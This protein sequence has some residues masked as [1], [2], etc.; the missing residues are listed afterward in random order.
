MFRVGVKRRYGKSLKLSCK[1]VTLVLLAVVVVLLLICGCMVIMKRKFLF[2][3]QV[4]LPV[5]KPPRTVVSVSSF[6]QR[7][8]HMQECLDSIMEQSMLADRVIVT[9]PLKFRGKEETS[10]VGWSD[11]VEYDVH[12]NENV[13]SMVEWFGRYMGIPYRYSVQ[14]HT[15]T[16]KTLFLY[17]FGNLT[18]QFLESD[19]G[20]ATKLIGALLL[21]ADPET[22]I[23]T[24][25][26]DMVYNHETVQWLSTHIQPNIALSFGCES[27]SDDTELYIGGLATGH[28]DTV[29]WVLESHTL[30]FL[31]PNPRIC[32]G[33]LLG[34]EGVAY[35]TS[36]FGPDIWKFLQSLPVGC[37]YNDDIWLSG[38]VARRGVRR[39]ASL[40]IKHHKHTRDKSLSISTI[41]DAEDKKYECARHLFSIHNA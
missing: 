26:D 13:S 36:S 24:F 7:V 19:W 33:W 28:D 41:F 30:S 11:T 31:M 20:P 27:W 35:H 4:V 5:H 2:T 15:D 21:E 37:F 22:V 9:I 3:E 40:A 16:N 8:F 6:S 25:D 12:H 1:H 29:L 38:Y 17:E 34:F 14:T 10:D 23:I 32:N 39:V 18:V